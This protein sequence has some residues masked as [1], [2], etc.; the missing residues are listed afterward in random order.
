MKTLLMTLLLV[1]IGSSVAAQDNK[2]SVFKVYRVYFYNPST[3]TTDQTEVD[4]PMV[5]SNDVIS[6]DNKGAQRIRI[7]LVT[8]IDEKDSKTSSLY[9]RGVD[10]EGRF[11]TMKLTFSP[12][13]NYL[14]VTLGNGIKTS[15]LFTSY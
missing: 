7:T 15:Y 3:N 12:T 4:Y 6:F 2:P 8:S 5:I 10:K 13:I 11:V 9:S 1:L 14:V